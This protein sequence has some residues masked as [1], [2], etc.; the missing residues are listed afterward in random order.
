LNEV[1]GAEAGNEPLVPLSDVTD[2]P[3]VL[4]RAFQADTCVAGGI[5]NLTR[6][7]AAS[8]P[9]WQA[10]VRAEQVFATFV[11]IDRKTQA[12]LT[13]YVSMLNNSTYCIDD[14]AGAALTLGVPAG[15]LR[16][17]E[18]PTSAVFDGR[19]TALL[20][21]AYWVVASPDSIP[22]GVLRALKLHCD[23]EEILEATTII[24]M[25]CFWNHFVT[26][27]AIPMDERCADRVLLVELFASAATG[28]A[29]PVA[30]PTR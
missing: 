16:A 11:R 29:R 2:V 15:E 5:R 17:L 27:L 13:T 14:C 7:V 30:E 26:A 10:V 24:A 20:D 6:V 4:Q 22:D 19:T 9:A 21:Y 28:V 1:Q 18:R 25:K 3:E 12:I 8:K 23:S